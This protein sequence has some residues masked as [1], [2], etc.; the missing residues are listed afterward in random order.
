MISNQDYFAFRRL[1]KNQFNE[2]MIKPQLSQ[3]WPGSCL[4]QHLSCKVGPSQIGPHSVSRWCK[5]K[6]PSV[7]PVCIELELTQ[8][9]CDASSSLSKTVLVILTVVS[10]ILQSHADHTNAECSFDFIVFL[11]LLRSWIICV[12]PNWERQCTVY[13]HGP[14]V[15]TWLIIEVLPML[16]ML[17]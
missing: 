2:N 15:L 16:E 5:R 3:Y 4:M 12:P 6:H 13:T 11:W 9:G 17:I 14:A 10:W 8:S 1:W 7:L